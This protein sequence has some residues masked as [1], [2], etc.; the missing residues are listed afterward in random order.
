MTVQ[1]LVLT[2]EIDAIDEPLPE[3]PYEA[4]ANLRIDE[5]IWGPEL[6]LCGNSVS[7]SQAAWDQ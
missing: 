3:N 6:S 2:F 4:A 5:G 7:L 1:R